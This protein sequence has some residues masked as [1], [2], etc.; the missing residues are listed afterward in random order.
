MPFEQLLSDGEVKL[1]LVVSDSLFTGD[2]VAI[3]LVTAIELSSVG[4][5]VA[6]IDPVVAELVGRA[7]TLS[8][9]TGEVVIIIPVDM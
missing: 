6:C 3:S 9:G 5:A 8:T 4:V 1:M 2:V 7:V